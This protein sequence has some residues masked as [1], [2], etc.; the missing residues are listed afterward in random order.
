MGTDFCHFLIVH[1]YGVGLDD[2]DTSIVPSVVVPYAQV[3]LLAPPVP[4]LQGKVVL[5]VVLAGI[6]EVLLDGLENLFCKLLVLVVHCACLIGYTLYI[7]KC[8]PD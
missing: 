6:V 2:A 4:I 3:N 8:V 7:A 5:L 1:L